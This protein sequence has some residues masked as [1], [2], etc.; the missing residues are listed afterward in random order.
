MLEFYNGFRIPF[1]N[2]ATLRLV[3]AGKRLTRARARSTP[4]GRGPVAALSRRR[5]H[6]EPAV[7]IRV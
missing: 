6:A 5:Q 2:R 1:A 3:D 7:A 4:T